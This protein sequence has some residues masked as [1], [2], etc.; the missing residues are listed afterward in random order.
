M[1][2]ECPECKKMIS[3]K[4]TMCPNCGFP[5]NKIQ[6]QNDNDHEALYV[7]H[8]NGILDFYKKIGEI[9]NLNTLT[10]IKEYIDKNPNL[11]KEYDLAVSNNKKTDFNNT[12][13]CPTCGSTNI[14]KISTTERAVKTAL[15]GVIGAVDDAGKTYK[16][17]NC[18]SK[19]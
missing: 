5:I 12:P 10:E 7:L 3:D 6:K 14:Q 9:H 1:L 2:I 16:C 15:F 19:F 13:K 11:K 8:Q 4:A 18:G 17:E